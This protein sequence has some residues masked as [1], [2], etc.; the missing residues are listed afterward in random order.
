MC[1]KALSKYLGRAF[2]GFLLLCRTSLVFDFKKS[3]QSGISYNRTSKSID[4][5]VDVSKWAHTT[6]ET[7]AEI[8]DVAHEV[9]HIQQFLDGALSFDKG[10]G[11][12]GALYDITDEIQAYNIQATIKNNGD[13]TADVFSQ[14]LPSPYTYLIDRYEVLYLG[15]MSNVDYS[16]VPTA[17]ASAPVHNRNG[18][19]IPPALN[20]DLFIYRK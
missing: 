16:T 10:T 19:T 18:N 6:P 8:S 17:P 3:T 1:N 5:T 12:A 9:V 14:K 15:A 11:E 4:I 20:N 7:P 2:V 13:N